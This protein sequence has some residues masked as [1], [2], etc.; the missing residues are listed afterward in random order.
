MPM[1]LVTPP[2]VPA[3][4]FGAWSVLDKLVRS[5]PCGVPAHYIAARCH[6]KLPKLDVPITPWRTATCRP[7]S[8]VIT[9][10][11]FAT[12]QA[13]SL[14]VSSTRLDAAEFGVGFRRLAHRNKQVVSRCRHWLSRGHPP[15]SV[16]ARQQQH[17]AGHRQKQHRRH[18]RRQM[19]RPPR[20][21]GK[22]AGPQPPAAQAA[23]GCGR[24][25]GLPCSS[26]RECSTKRSC[27]A[28]AASAKPQANPLPS[29]GH[30]RQRPPLRL[31]IIVPQAGLLHG[32]SSGRSS[33]Q[34]TGI[35]WHRAASFTGVGFDDV[36]T[37]HSDAVQGLA[38]SD[39]MLTAGRGC[40]CAC[41]C[42]IMPACLQ[43]KRATCAL[44]KAQQLRPTLRAA[45]CTFPLQS[46]AA[47][48][49]ASQRQAVSGAAACDST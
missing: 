44:M 12:R 7:L 41:V 18:Q 19:R 30:C 46:C 34:M 5:A 14:R 17:A 48:V 6:Q 1:G 40:T 11:P 20:S 9:R 38:A 35:I 2:L 15:R 39:N 29:A 10:C 43:G 28:A 45:L 25:A 33:S 13:A 16:A 32:N 26:A 23:H 22:P 47:R 3:C 36:F 24:P 49:A 31:C 21:G 4:I 42:Q 27:A 37:T 8:R